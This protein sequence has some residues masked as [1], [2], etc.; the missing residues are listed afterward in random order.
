MS[1]KLHSIPKEA[2]FKAPKDVIKSEEV[3]N[4]LGTLPSAT[5][6]N[7]ADGRHT[8]PDG[9]SDHVS[10][11]EDPSDDTI[12]EN[13]EKLQSEIG[14][15]SIENSTDSNTESDCDRVKSDVESVISEKVEDVTDKTKTVEEPKIEL[16]TVELRYDEQSD[17]T[18][19]KQEPCTKRPVTF[20]QEIQDSELD[21]DNKLSDQSQKITNEVKPALKTFEEEVADTSLGE[22]DFK[23][24]EQQQKLE[25]VDEE[26][27]YFG[28][29]EKV[30]PE[31]DKTLDTTFE[32]EVQDVQDDLDSFGDFDKATAGDPDF[33]SEVTKVPP[34]TLDDDLEDEDE[35][36]DFD[37][38]S[39]ARTTE[40]VR[41]TEAGSEEFASTSGWASLTP[42][43]SPKG[44]LDQI[45]IGV[46]FLAKS[47]LSCIT[48]SLSI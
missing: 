7:L 18:E 16:K 2:I 6:V 11:K 30:Q 45:L 23:P 22:F 8:P 46:R 14:T 12:N 38:A 41:S 48:S 20:E 27:D 3:E 31:Q 19:T 32:Q 47:I 13:S 42:S 10:I 26:T 43:S 39:D 9:H 24:Q 5:N 15:N 35:F 44:H 28:D 4:S 33:E 1:D 29:F 17:E 25:Q 21:V 34:L 37:S 36:G 40:V